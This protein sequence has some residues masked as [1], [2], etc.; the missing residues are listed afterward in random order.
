[1]NISMIKKNIYILYLFSLPIT[2]ILISKRYIY[3]MGVSLSFYISIIGILLICLD[4]LKSK[5]VYIE[6]NTRRIVVMMFCLIISSIF[7]AIVLNYELGVLFGRNT[8]IAILPQIVYV[9]QIIIT[10]IYNGYMLR[11][12]NIKIIL[13]IIYIS[14]ICTIIYGYIQIIIMKFDVSFFNNIYIKTIGFI[15]DSK[16]PYLIGIGEV[17]LL[18]LEAST[19]GAFLSIYILPFI[20]ACYRNKYISLNKFIFLLVS[21]I[22]IIIYNN[23]SSALLGTVICLSIFFILEIN[24]RGLR[25]YKL[26]NFVV[27]IV[28]AS[29]GV[30]MFIESDIF[31][32]SEIYDRTI[33][34]I[35][36]NKDLSTVH[37]SSS[38]ITNMM[39]F[40]EHPILGVGNG[41]QG[42]YYVKH[43]PQWAFKSYESKALYYGN[44]GWPGS[45]AFIPTLISGYGILGIVIFIC[46]ITISYRNLRKLKDNKIRIIYDF[47]LLAFIG[48]I[49]Q[50]YTTIN[51]IGEYWL[52]FLLSLAIKKYD[53]RKCEYYE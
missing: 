43:L 46:I 53:L 9:L 40:K 31:K 41:N 38:I 18:T 22:P 26:I 25:K 21:L 33:G 44:S 2:N 39:A 48:F 12:V 10:L 16:N 17:N 49:F 4:M 42:F 15:E 24:R 11:D 36:S 1:M 23:S 13:K 34:K 6:K 29:I 52:I 5:T 45:G 51:V 28:I 32:H 19:A 20:L 7:M 37:R 8:Y 50:S 47:L 14:I 27:I 35:S 30:G 3:S